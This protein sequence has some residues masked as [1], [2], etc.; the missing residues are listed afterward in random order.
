MKSNL[1]SRPLFENSEFET[2]DLAQL[3]SATRLLYG[4]V[5]WNQFSGELVL[6]RP[7]PLTRPLLV[8]PART[9]SGQPLSG[10]R[11]GKSA[12]LTGVCTRFGSLQ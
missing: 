5:R 10:S 8:Y 9:D 12:L 2:D 7:A 3:H 6:L 11:C 4:N 1:P